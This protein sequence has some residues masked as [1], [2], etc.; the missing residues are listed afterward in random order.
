MI[1]ATSSI[2]P[3]KNVVILARDVIVLTSNGD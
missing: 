1:I 3:K 2:P